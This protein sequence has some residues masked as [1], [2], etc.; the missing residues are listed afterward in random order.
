MIRYLRNLFALVA[1]S[2][3]AYIVG[4]ALNTQFVLAA[5]NVPVSFGDRFNMTMFD[6]SNML[7][8]LIIILVGFLTAFAIASFVKSRLPRL[9]KYAYPVAGAAALGGILGLMYILF[10]TVPISG[11][12]SAL[13]FLAQVLAGGFGGWVF[14]RVIAPKADATK[15]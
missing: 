14:A 11:A 10:Q 1:A 9:A 6:I 3:A 4:T 13:G 15:A 12:R 8:Y 2:I 7:L 5:H